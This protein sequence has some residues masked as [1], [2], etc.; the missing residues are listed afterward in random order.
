MKSHND[1]GKSTVEN[2]SEQEGL[3]NKSSQLA[4][5]G[6]TQTR[7]PATMLGGSQGNHVSAYALIERSLSMVIEDQE[8]PTDVVIM[9]LFQVVTEGLEEGLVHDLENDPIES[10]NEEKSTRKKRE[11][12]DEKDVIDKIKEKIHAIATKEWFITSEYWN[13]EELKNVNPDFLKPLKIAAYR[14]NLQYFQEVID[15]ITQLY[16]KAANLYMLGTFPK[17]GSV[18]SSSNEG[19]N[20]KKSLNLLD[21]VLIR[22]VTNQGYKNFNDKDFE[23]IANCMSSLFFYPKIPNDILL[24]IESNSTHKKQW[25][26]ICNKQ[27]YPKG[28]KPRDNKFENLYKVTAR[29]IKLTFICYPTFT[30]EEIRGTIIERFVSKIADSWG[31]SK[32]ERVDF[33]TNVDRLLPVDFNL[34]R[35]LQ[36]KNQ[37]NAEDTDKSVKKSKN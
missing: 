30:E 19:A 13:S 5:L 29:H 9:R 28:T 4:V 31:M 18:A 7:R 26:D 11:K 14:S 34:P 21:A 22:A 20:I 12:S 24:D 15:D 10:T 3:E 17:E 6:Y 8:C 1:S 23:E 33:L 36:Q 27:K 32:E 25:E 2:A 37:T 16:L 35:S